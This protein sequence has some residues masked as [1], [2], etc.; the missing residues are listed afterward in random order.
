MTNPVTSELFL[1]EEVWICN[2]MELQND[3]LPS[4]NRSSM[5]AAV[6]GMKSDYNTTL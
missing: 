6:V 2:C 5:T 3:P 1:F 4:K